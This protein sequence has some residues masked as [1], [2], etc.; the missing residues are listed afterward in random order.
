MTAHVRQASR[1]DHSFLHMATALCVLALPALLVLTF[2]PAHAAGF[3][4]AYT[5]LDLDGCEVLKEY[6]EGGGVDLKCAG[7]R[8]IP[9]F[10]SEGDLRTVVGFGTQNETGGTFAPFNSPGT[11]VEWRLSGGKPFAAILRFH[12]DPGD[13]SGQTVSVLGV[14]TIGGNGRESCPVGYVDAS[15]NADANVLARKVADEEAGGFACG[16][17][18]P[19]Y[20]GAVS[21]LGGSATAVR[22]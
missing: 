19:R 11:T 12:L 1:C 6:E 7:Y 2:A 21:E 8:G 9:V 13:G 17:D 5:K 4:S 16:T 14:H 15:V 20:R 22:Y 3:D 10:V 18:R